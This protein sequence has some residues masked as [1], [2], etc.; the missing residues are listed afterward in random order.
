MT[1][2]SGHAAAP[3]K[4]IDTHV[5]FYDPTRPDGVPWPP[6]SDTLLY[7]R[8]LPAD[9]ERIAKPLGVTGVVEV[10]ASPL[11]SDNRW[12][13][14]LAEKN[15]IIVGTVGNLEPEKPAF[16][17]QLEQFHKNPLFRGI[18]CGN[19]WNRDL[20]T[21]LSDP[22]FIG[23]LRLVAQA[24]LAM[25]TANPS[26][27]LLATIVRLTDQVP[28]LRIVIDHLPI[29]TPQ[30]QDDRT[31]LESSL[32]ELARRPQVYI[33]V[34]NV[35]RRVEGHVPADSAHYRRPLDQ[36]W[37]LF[38]ADRLIYGSNWPVSEAVA[39]YPVA[40]KVVCEYFGSRGQEAAEKY[41]WRNATRAYRLA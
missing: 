30:N 17:G 25:D 19:L 15:P 1:S 23:G 2:G 26:P 11:A 38:G 27:A 20:A 4:I 16:A 37:N 34:S 29:D 28:G 41:F 33:K 14:D 31:Q 40:L 24:D 6:K 10:E 21:Q 9:L 32:R 5:H 22:K 36:L 8:V 39:P 3:S 7:R 35:L 18:R 12:V 13:L